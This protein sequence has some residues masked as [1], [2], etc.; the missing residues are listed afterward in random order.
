MADHHRNG[1]MSP[2]ESPGRTIWQWLLY[3]GGVCLEL[4][5]IAFTG[6]VVA[7]FFGNVDTRVLLSLTAVGM[8]LFYS[9]WWFVRYASRAGPPARRERG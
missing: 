8:I 4:L 6:A 5:G 3:C 2:V 1:H 9:G 7:V